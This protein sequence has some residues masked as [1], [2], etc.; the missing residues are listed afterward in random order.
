MRKISRQAAEAFFAGRPFK[1][2]NTVVENTG[3]V[4]ALKLWGNQIAS[5]NLTETPLYRNKT[6]R[7]SLCGWNTVTT[8]ERLY[9]LGVTL[10][11]RR[12]NLY[13]LYNGRELLINDTAGYA[14]DWQEAKD[15][16]DIHAGLGVRCWPNKDLRKV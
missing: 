16:A 15:M 6:L 2:N 4:V 12:G 1:K 9:A 5:Y 11:K 3:L 7:F 10:F 13:W 14:I 8:R